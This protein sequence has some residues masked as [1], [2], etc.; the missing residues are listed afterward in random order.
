MKTRQIHVAKREVERLRLVADGATETDLAIWQAE[1]KVADLERRERQGAVSTARR[2]AL[3][4]DLVLTAVAVLVMGFSLGNI[5]RFALGHGVGDPIAWFLAPAVDLA[6]IGALMGD[7]VLSR[8]QLDA[9]PWAARLRWFAGLATL[10]LNAWEAVAA[11]DAAAI[12]T[13]AVPPL[14]LIILAEAAVPY[15]RRFT[16]TV[17][18]ARRAVEVDTPAPE[19]DTEAVHQVSRWT[20]TPVHP[21]PEAVEAETVD[22]PQIAPPRALICG[23]N[24]GANLLGAVE[25][26]AAEVDTDPED[27]NV[28][29][30]DRLSAEEA[31]AA[32]IQAWKDGLSTREAGRLATRS[33]SYASRVFRELEA[34][35]GPQPTA[36]QLALVRAH[37]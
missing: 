30:P 22:R 14:L 13:H 11:R 20:S 9:G 33:S 35:R 16:E 37:A 1:C 36:G 5:H 25:P 26:T 3:G 24:L 31:K 8:H 21:A 19:V 23:A 12:V 27:G 32:L 2:A 28:E 6:L 18:I 4:M 17:E 15:R 34:E 10:A 7:A 29:E